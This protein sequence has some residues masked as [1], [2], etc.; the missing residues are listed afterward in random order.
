M[1]ENGAINNDLPNG[2]NSLSPVNHRM[3][4]KKIMQTVQSELSDDISLKVQRQMIAMNQL[5][6][7]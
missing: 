5:S 7:A 2:D 4:Q 1:P 6:E 3:S